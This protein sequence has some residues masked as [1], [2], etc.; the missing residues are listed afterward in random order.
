[1]VWKESPADV[2]TA[3]P[4]VSF[5]TSLPVVTVTVRAPGVALEAI[6]T[7]AVHWGSAGHCWLENVM[8]VP[9]LKIEDEEKCVWVPLITTW[10]NEVRADPPPGET[11]ATTATGAVFVP[12]P[13]S[14]IAIWL[15]LDAA[16]I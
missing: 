15:E 6:V 4:A 9:K 11:P 2:A 1:M 14:S 3:K 10:V 7:V 8:P 5:A 13:V 16:V 12:V